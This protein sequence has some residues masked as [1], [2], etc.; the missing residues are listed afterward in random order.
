MLHKNSFK[1]TL[2]VLSIISSILLTAC[3]KVAATMSTEDYILSEEGATSKGIKIGDSLETFFDAY[4]NHAML[5]SYG[6]EQYTVFHKKD[7]LTEDHTF[8]TTTFSLLLPTFFVDNEAYSTDQICE[9]YQVTKENL[10]SFLNSEDFLK[11]HSVIYKFIL[12]DFKDGVLENILE[13]SRDFNAELE[14]A[15]KQ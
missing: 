1:R 4:E 5:I 6:D 13:S 3:N 7:I 8:S 10:L 9:T 15:N 11:E 14:Y 12:F 2:L